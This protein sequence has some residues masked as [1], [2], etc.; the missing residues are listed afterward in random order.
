MGRTWTG[1]VVF[2]GVMV[3]LGT[4][5]W[6][7]DVCSDKELKVAGDR[8]L[9]QAEE[10]ERA[11]KVR[12]A[13]SAA[14][15]LNGECITDYKR[16]EALKARTAKAIGAEGE[17]KGKYQEAFDWYAR[18]Q[19]PADAGRMQRKLVEAN[20]DDR[21]VVS[22]AIDYFVYQ[23]DGMQ[24]KAMR[25]HAL[26]NVEK[27]LANEEKRFALATKDSLEELGLAR[28]WAYYAQ[29]GEDRIRARA[30]KRGDTLDAEQGRKFL[31][32]ALSYYAAA[33]QPDKEQKVREKA[34]VLAKQHESKGEGE[35]AAEYYVIAGDSTNAEAV[36]KQSELRQQ[37][38]EESRKK[39]F[40]KGQSDLEKALGF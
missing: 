22:H 16:H 9:K 31:S 26:K 37:Q 29:T 33:G 27:A 21:N 38:A 32:L 10:L 3:L 24:E 1:I 4:P 40:K 17:K 19:S 36:R 2:A 34:L 30:A 28:D 18:A 25:A 6:A 7:D 20:P 5:A 14:D 39:T 15:K 11:G 35:I 23:K 12:E 8:K 13:Y